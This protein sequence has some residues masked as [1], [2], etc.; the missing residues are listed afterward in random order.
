M[1]KKTI[2]IFLL[3]A[4][5]LSALTACG[6]GN[7]G[8]VEGKTLFIYLCGSNLETKQGL[9]SKNIDELLSA[10]IGDMNIVIQTGG[11]KTW[12]HHDISTDTAQRYEIKNGELK[13]IETLEQKNMGEA[14][15]LTDFLIW[16]QEQYPTNH[17][18]LVL[19]DHGGG[20]A[21]GVCFD[22]NYGFDGLTLTELHS[23]LD[24]AK[25]NTK[26][27]IIGFDACLMA[28]VE[29]A[30]AVQDFAKYMIASEEI[31]PSG[32]WDYKTVAETF[33]S[34]T[35]LLETG[36][37]ICDSFLTKCKTA[38]KDT[39]A[40]LSVFDLSKTD[41]LIEKF[42]DV[43]GVLT[44]NIN[45]NNFSSFITDSLNRTETMGGDRTADGGSNM[46]D[47]IS[48][49]TRVALKIKDDVQFLWPAVYDLV[50][51][52]V[53]GQERF[54]CGMSFYYPERYDKNEI[55]SYTALGVCEA[56]NSYLNEYY[57]HV[58]DT[59]IEYAERGSISE[60]GAFTASLSPESGKYLSAIDFLLMETDDEGKRHI[61][62][63]DND[64]TKDW[65]NLVFKSNF[66]GISLALD[67]HRMYFDTTSSTDVMIK[68][69]APVKVNGKRTNLIFLFI[70]DESYFNDG[71]YEVFGTWDGYDENGLPSND[72]N[73]LKKGD[74][75]Q[76]VTDVVIDDGEEEEIYG[77]EF[78]I[79][80]DGGEIT[81]LPLDGKTYQYV[82][83]ATDI[84][85]NTFYSD[86]ATFEMT[87]SYEELSANPLPDGEYAAKVTKIEPYNV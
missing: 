4:L 28:T 3:T 24:A 12:R 49:A 21:K 76:V 53:T 1:L 74:K 79:E 2:A 45:D 19:W 23:A 60:N 58:P 71:Y 48:F 56:Y 40:A 20:A 29:T 38:G 68:F 6:E 69:S 62:C 86:M 15:T 61:L 25:L 70:W 63:S 44:K 81:E 77:E 75:V 13:L 65:D 83:V 39:F 80:K 85:G 52:S 87:K 11:A 9:A 5:L 43:I 72:Y 50:P 57:L 33:A 82:F 35:D 37:S 42:S 27:D 14:E 8:T 41:A 18:M 64:I 78:V 30:D 66:R 84:F 67:G 36:K 31:E 55:E 16:G 54:T 47:M 34:G 59:T 17:N 10:D 26:F 22:E 7:G 32:G 46:I 51:Y 73:E